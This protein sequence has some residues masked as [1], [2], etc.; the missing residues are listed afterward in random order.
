[1]GVT[2][3]V[4]EQKEGEGRGQTLGGQLLIRTTPSCPCRTDCSEDWG[5]DKA[6]THPI[7]A[8]IFDYHL[9]AR[10]S[11]FKVNNRSGK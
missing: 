1:M 2:E 6:Y 8:Q 11:H 4:G 9:T 7:S 3:L 10:V 5:S